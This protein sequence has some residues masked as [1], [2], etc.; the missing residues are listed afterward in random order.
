MEETYPTISVITPTLNA[1][2]VLE[3]ELKS[4]REQD[5][6]QEKV[7]IIIADGGSTDTTLKIAKKYGAKVYFNPLKTGEAGKA[8]AV[9]KAMNELIALIDSDNILPQ[10]DWFKK[11]VEPFLNTEIVGSEPWEYTYRKEGGFIER[12][13]SLIG[14]NDPIVM[15]YGNYDRINTLTGKWT[16]VSLKQ[17]DRGNWIEVLLEKGKE[18]PTIGA[19]GTLFRSE[20]LKKALLPP[21][22]LSRAQLDEGST[23]NRST[24][25]LFDIDV[26]VAEIKKRNKIKFAKIKVG[27]IHTF[28]ESSISKF[29]RKQK[30]RVLDYFYYKSIG[31]RSVN[32]ESD[33]SKKLSILRFSLY[34]LLVIPAVID[35][36]R[37]LM[38]KR[39]IA[40]FFHPLACGITLYFYSTGVIS[41][42]LW[43]AKELSRKSWKQ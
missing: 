28:C 10:K 34:T 38:K 16:E 7:E 31:V 5:Y 2:S 26:L 9:K 8:V 11:M 42:K 6:P 22:I 1:G 39:D 41:N 30:R 13:C 29:Y 17:I 43:G 25:Y 27:I 14:M 12:Y 19:N 35:S 21:V 23:S 32:W 4:I 24:D 15:F 40:W 33:A 20:F 37:G 36:I 18:I 3:A